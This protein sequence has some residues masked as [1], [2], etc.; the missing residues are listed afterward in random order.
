LTQDPIHQ[1]FE[2]VRT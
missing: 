2:L 1:S